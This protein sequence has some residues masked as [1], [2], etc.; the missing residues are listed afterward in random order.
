MTKFSPF[1]ARKNILSFYRIDLTKDGVVT[2]ADFE[3]GGKRQATFLG[4]EPDSERFNEIVQ[5][6]VGIWETYYKP[7]DRDGV[8]AV[9]LF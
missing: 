6:W 2:Q 7:A 9:E 4:I 1:V 5:G 8:G 3:L